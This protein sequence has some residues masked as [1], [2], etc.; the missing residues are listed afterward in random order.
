MSSPLS[1][2]L[3]VK[4][5]EDTSSHVVTTP[6]PSPP[7]TP[8]SQVKADRIEEEFGSNPLDISFISSTKR[9]NI[10][11]DRKQ[12]NLLYADTTGT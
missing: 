1:P 10:P 11:T 8:R 2:K 7:L 5:E 3:E 6:P 4:L 9:T 12:L